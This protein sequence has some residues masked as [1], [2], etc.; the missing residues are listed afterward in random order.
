[1]FPVSRR[2]CLHWKKETSGPPWI[3][4]N[5][6]SWSPSHTPSRFSQAAS[7]NKAEKYNTDEHNACL[8]EVKRETG[9]ECLAHSLC[10]VRTPQINQY[11]MNSNLVGKE[12]KRTEI[13]PTFKYSQISPPRRSQTSNPTNTW[14]FVSWALFWIMEVNEVFSIFL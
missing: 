11:L 13:S 14:K 12:F 9:E 7:V 8:W 10:S 6:K 3:C 1:M 4:S 5:L 2:D